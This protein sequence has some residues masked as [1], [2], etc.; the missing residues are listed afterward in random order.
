MLDLSLAHCDL[1]ISNPALL[2]FKVRIITMSA[3]EIIVKH[4]S[5]FVGTEFRILPDSWGWRIG[6][7]VKILLYHHENWSSGAQHPRKCQVGEAIFLVSQGTGGRGEDPRNEMDHETSQISEA[8]GS[9]MRPCFSI[10][11]RKQSRKILNLTSGLHRLKHMFTCTHKCK[12]ASTPAPMY[13]CTSTPIHMCWWMYIHTHKMQ[14]RISSDTWH[15]L[16]YVSYYNYELLWFT[17][18]I[19]IMPLACAKYQARW[20]VHFCVPFSSDTQWWM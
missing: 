9:V 13:E 15:L 19:F 12:H 11:S 14:K 10:W 2:V 4:E 7:R 20:G 3:F 1:M 16:M 6:Q 17:F 8:L 18:Q 5:G